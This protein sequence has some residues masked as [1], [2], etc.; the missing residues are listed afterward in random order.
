MIMDGRELFELINA[1]ARAKGLPDMETV[2][3][4]REYL[5]RVFPK[6]RDRA[7]F[8]ATCYKE[9]SEELGM[10]SEEAVEWF[11]DG[12]VNGGNILC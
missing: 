9:C 2:M 11:R 8:I 7:A 1:V 4:A 5:H 12:C 3:E 10:T 6:P